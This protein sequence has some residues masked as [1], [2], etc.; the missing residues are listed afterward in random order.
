MPGSFLFFRVF[1]V[2]WGIYIVFP[3]EK[4][5]IF[6]DKLCRLI[7][8]P[9]YLSKFLT[10]NTAQYHFILKKPDCLCINP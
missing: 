5:D 4:D 2:E 8:F 1:C 10:V 7:L 9:N 3:Q 6:L